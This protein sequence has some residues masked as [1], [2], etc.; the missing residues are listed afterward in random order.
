[1][2]G[3]ESERGWSAFIV[4]LAA[5]VLHF[6][7]AIFIGV[8]AV[9]CGTTMYS[10][11]EVTNPG[12]YHVIT[13]SPCQGSDCFYEVQQTYEVAQDGLGWNVFALLAGFEWIS[14]SFA[15]WHLS[16][17]T[18]E[19]GWCSRWVFTAVCVVWNFAGALLLL[20][21]S[22]PMS[23]LQAALTVLSL[24]AATV[25]QVWP[26]E[27]AFDKGG[28]VMH[29]TEYCTSASLLFVAVLI[30]FV[31]EPISW[32]STV[33]F[34]G[35][36]LCNILGVALHVSKVDMPAPPPWREAFDFDWGNPRNHFKL[37]LIHSWLALFMAV[38]LIIY[39]ARG[40]IT[41]PDVPLFVQFIFFNLLV[42]YSLFGVWATACYAVSDV[43]KDSDWWVSEGLGTGLAVL[44]ALDKIP[45][46]YAVFYGL[47][48]QPNSGQ[49]CV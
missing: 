37:F 16:P 46:V 18:Q 47:V 5:F 22:T 33:G 38:I 23:F 48:L 13:P 7:S 3:S 4:H 27:G 14:A 25:A 35:V 44:S 2:Q 49:T 8:A 10:Y 39:F 20:P 42:T 34:T 29:Y 30:L 1:M 36:L 21:Y 43:S 9:K 32:G 45:V 40:M 41:D 17:K 15:L 11:T 28:V 19:R 6:C 24:A 12:G 26:M 31:P